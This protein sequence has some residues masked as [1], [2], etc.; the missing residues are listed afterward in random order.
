MEFVSV[1]GEMKLPEATVVV[2][3]RLKIF[4]SLVE[5][6]VPIAGFGFR[7]NL[8]YNQCFCIILR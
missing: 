6:V 1:Q 2:A 8:N 5:G 7:F 3:K 4:F